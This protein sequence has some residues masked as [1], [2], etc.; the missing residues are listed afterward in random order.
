MDYINE[1]DCVELDRVAA[2]KNDI[3]EAKEHNSALAREIAAADAEAEALVAC[4]SKLC[5]K[6]GA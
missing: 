2:L 6:L 5:E 3:Q 1:A 4:L